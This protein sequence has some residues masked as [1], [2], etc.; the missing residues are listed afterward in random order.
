MVQSKEKSGKI[1]G[2]IRY[3]VFF[4][5]LIL[6]LASFVGFG[7]LVLNGSQMQNI[8]RNATEEYF[9]SL[10]NDS[11]ARFS[12]ILNAIEE[13]SGVSQI[14]GE[15]FYSLKDTLSRREL[16]ENMQ[17]EY[18]AAYARETAL[19]GG[20]AFYEPYAF[21]PDVYDFHF[22]ASKDLTG[23]LAENNVRWIGDEWAWDVDTYEEGWYLSALPK[24]WNRST[25][26]SERYYWSELYEDTSINVLMVSVCLP[27]YSPD[28]R[29]VGVATVD[30]S[31]QTLEE[32]VG[33]FALPTP[34][35]HIAGFSTVNNATFAL[36]GS[37]QTGI[38]PY[39][40]NS[41]LTQ[42]GGLKTGQNFRNENLRID[43][44]SYTLVG[45]VH[46]SGIGLAFLIPNAEKFMAVDALQTGNMITAGAVALVMIVIIVV[47]I[48]ALSRWIVTPIKRAGVLFENLA[49]G[50]LTQ[51]ITVRGNDELSQMMRTLGKMQESIKNLIRNIKNEADSLSDIG[52]DLATNMNNTAAAVR[53]ITA[54]VQNIKGRVMNQ[55]A[56]VSQ[57][58]A[59][60]ED[61]VLNIDKLK[62]HVENQS[63]HIAQASAS[64]EEMVANINSVTGT[65]VNNSTNVQTLQEASEVGRSGLQEVAG[66]IQE[67]ARES[68]GLLEINSVMQNIASQTN[69]L[70]MNA[71]IEAAH[72]GEAGKGFAVVAD[73]IRKLAENS[74]VQSK[75]IGSVLKK[76]KE[77]IDKI[78]HS[79]ENV[80]G[81]FEAIDSSV[82]IVTEQEEN[83]R[84][85]MEEQGQG[86]KQ[87]LEGTG[88]LNEITREVRSGSNEMHEGAQEVIRE[89]KNLE[90]ATQEITI[91]MNET[92]TGVEHI[93]SAV[94]YVNGISVRNR[95]AIDV[96]IKEV[97]RFRV[98]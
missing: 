2:S 49:Q 92:T 76:I 41:W 31:L 48:L 89:S 54:N 11:F 74:S 53:Q 21:Y 82:K 24:G 12:N 28:K 60:M 35:S 62:N 6:S 83:I 77:S 34:S 32:M 81:K 86:S 85:A 37:N 73:E 70:S 91:G 52:N 66:N 45:S 3:K 26:R 94:N 68:E 75:T 63:G 39:P 93:N 20:G 40:V 16:A 22:F 78:T 55:S 5:I 25:P 44:Q 95:K 69:L 23:S 36:S 8:A 58:H 10:A 71:A 19:L 27:V 67:I 88:T 64:I 15:T 30:V 14:L 29:I 42:L 51:T 47:V 97:A 87:I 50:D 18:R 65:L 46:K 33:A 7:I 57:T 1:T 4:L 43:G 61:L 17:A 96:L 13:S 72:A 38:H 9:D 84:N 90:K 56:S 80:L 79:T 59:T 98:E